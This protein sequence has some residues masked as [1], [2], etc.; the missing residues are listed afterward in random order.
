MFVK[1]GKKSSPEISGDD[2]SPVLQTLNI[3]N[4]D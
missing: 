4:M 2:S 1:L 3:V